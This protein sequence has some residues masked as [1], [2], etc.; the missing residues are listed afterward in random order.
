MILMNIKEKLKNFWKAYKKNWLWICIGVY[1]GTMLMSWI[2]YFRGYFSLIGV[3]LPTFIIPL[4]L[5]G[6]F[7]I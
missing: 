4:F 5:F 1:I 3:V 2:E 6:I 7:Y